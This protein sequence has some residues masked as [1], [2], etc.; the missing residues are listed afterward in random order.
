MK[1]ILFGIFSSF[2]YDWLLHTGEQFQLNV[3][4]ESTVPILCY[5]YRS[6]MK[7]ISAIGTL[8]VFIFFFYLSYNEHCI[9][10]QRPGTF[11]YQFFLMSRF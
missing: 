6:L 9:V 11:D 2:K 8:F 5:L 10:F 7:A 1:E 3:T 4:S